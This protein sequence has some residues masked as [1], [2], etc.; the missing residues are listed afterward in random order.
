MFAALID[1]MHRK[2]DKNAQL[3]NQLK[4]WDH[5]IRVVDKLLA[6]AKIADVSRVFFFYLKVNHNSF[7]FF[8]KFS[9]NA[10]LN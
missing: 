3:S 6:I 9:L 2:F 4:T 7:Q 10:N 5:S 8:F 1:A